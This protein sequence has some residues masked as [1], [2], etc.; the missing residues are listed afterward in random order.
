[1]LLCMFCGFVYVILHEGRFLVELVSYVVVH[2]SSQLPYNG[3]AIILSCRGVCQCDEYNIVLI[4]GGYMECYQSLRFQSV[5]Q[6]SSNISHGE[7]RPC[8]YLY[9]HGKQP[10]V[11][12]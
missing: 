10:C 2:V 9:F 5:T 3:M 12:G 8:S 4:H 11:C 6:Y 7:L 1:M